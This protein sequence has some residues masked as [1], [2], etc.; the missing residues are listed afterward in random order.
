MNNGSYC[1]KGFSTLNTK[2]IIKLSCVS[3]LILMLLQY[4]EKATLIARGGVISQKRCKNVT[5]G[6]R[7]PEVP[8]TACHDSMGICL[9]AWLTYFLAMIVCIAFKRS[10]RLNLTDFAIYCAIAIQI[11]EN[12]FRP[13]ISHWC[14][15]MWFW[16][17]LKKKKNAGFYVFK[18]TP[19]R[20]RNENRALKEYLYQP[21]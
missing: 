13:M 19:Y 20:E 12:T 15:A 11:W 4:Q 10:Q 3:K 8:A 17:K 16:H 5:S 9:G 7:C 18:W 1:L 21:L 14:T 2:E 6:Q